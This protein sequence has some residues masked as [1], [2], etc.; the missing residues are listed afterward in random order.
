MPEKTRCFIAVAIPEPLG[1]RLLGLQ[2]ELSS[3]VEDC[4]WTTSQPFHA[5]L[6]FLGDVPTAQLAWLCR[7]VAASAEPF[8]SFEV[9][10]EGIGVFPL[11]SHPRVLW[12][13]LTGPQHEPMRALQ[14]A[15]VGAV[16][17]AGHHIEPERFHPHVTIGRINRRRGAKG[18]LTKLIERFRGWSGGSFTVKEVVTFSSAPGP[19]GSVYTVIARALLATKND[20][21]TP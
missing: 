17:G 4:R 20:E 13:G 15:V 16:R 18:D 1:R 7:V 2:G 5:T 6:V 12:A 10:L 3:E 11:P 14:A 9:H 19:G 21:A 8:A